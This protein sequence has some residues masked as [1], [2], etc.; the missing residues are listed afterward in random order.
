MTILNVFNQDAF[1][2]LTLTSFIDRVPFSPTG[3]GELGLFDD[4]PIYTTALAVE[5]RQGKLVI[6]PTSARGA[7]P[8]ER[9]EQK[10]HARYFEVP[11][12]AHADTIFATE[13]QNVREPG[14]EAQLKTIQAEVAYRLAG[15]TGLT[16]SME[17]TWERHRLAAIQGLLLDANGSVL[18]NWFGE[19]GIAQPAAIDF[20]LGGWKAGAATPTADGALRT[21]CNTLVRS[22]ARSAQGAFTPRSRIMAACGDAFWDE[23]TTHPDVTKTF[24]NW[25][26]AAELRKGTA[27]QAY[28]FGGIDWFNYRGSDDNSTIAIPTNTAYFFPAN[29]PGIF[30]RALAPAE[31]APFVNTRGRPITILPIPDRDRQAWV[32]IEAYSYPL[33]ICLRP[34]VLRTGTTSS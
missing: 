12:L 27:F 33:H 21:A 15:P 18:Y 29:A 4:K 20:N 28:S 10:R 26:E 34:E 9:V 31:F 19:F 25:A 7:P 2:A 1:S 24:Y 8:V 16:S 5:D 32:R 17:Y 6:I 3:I 22:I 13:L 30:Q 11:R 23:L 14:S